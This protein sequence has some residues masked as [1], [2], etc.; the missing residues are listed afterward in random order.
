MDVGS[1]VKE[2]LNY[3]DW[4]LFRA[5]IV[6][7]WVLVGWIV[8]KNRYRIEQWART[9]ALPWLGDRPKVLRDGLKKRFRRPAATGTGS[10]RPS[11][12]SNVFGRLWERKILLLSVLPF[13]IVWAFLPG[14]VMATVASLGVVAIYGVMFWLVWNV[15]APQDKFFT[16]VPEGAA[17][18]IVRG[19]KSKERPEEVKGAVTKFLFQYKDHRLDKDWNLVAAKEHHVLGALRWVGIWP[20]DRIFSYPFTW[21]HFVAGEGPHTH[22]EVLDYIFCGKSDK[23]YQEAEGLED[24]DHLPLKVKV[25]LTLR[26]V[27]PY[28]ALFAINGWLRSTLA[29]MF[30]LLR[31]YIGQHTYDE[32]LGVKGSMGGELFTESGQL[33]D[34]IRDLHGVEVCAIE[35]LDFDPPAGYRA[36]TLRKWE[37]QQNSDAMA[38]D[39]K[40]K[41]DFYQKLS[42]A[43][44]GLTTNGAIL[45]AVQ[46]LIP[47][48]GP[49]IAAA[50]GG[51]V[52]IDEVV[53]RV[54]SLLA[55]QPVVQ[56]AVV[57]QG[58]P[59]PVQVAPTAGGQQVASSSSTKPAPLSAK[60]E[61]RLRIQTGRELD[62]QVAEQIRA[63]RR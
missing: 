63:K 22:N 13:A 34:Q 25:L 45:L 53:E 3:A 27:N 14:W 2:V 30:P 38:I 15:L 8:W 46:T 57:Q 37:A 5:V 18:A 36:A 44:A 52:D 24:K 59:V 1:V 20:F 6:S 43:T 17:K 54:R 51:R 60:D 28:K 31:D 35:I 9:K 26:V 49:I 50:K 48:I 32:L 16:F 41:Q 40:A 4:I 47:E 62:R 11:R 19:G 39:A 33:R 61:R 55:Q 42:A 21:Q 10:R 56:Q 23:Y 7:V 29:E 58:Q 12:P